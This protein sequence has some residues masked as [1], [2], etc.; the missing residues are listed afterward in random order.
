MGYV[1][2]NGVLKKFLYEDG[3]EEVVIPNNVTTIGYGAF[4]NNRNITSVI[5]PESIEEI[6][7]LAFKN[8]TKLKEIK[9]SDNVLKIGDCAFENCRNISSIMI[10]RNII[11]IKTDA[12]NDCIRLKEIIFNGYPK[13]MHGEVFSNTR[14]ERN[15]PDDFIVIGDLLYKYKGNDK[16]IEIPKGIKRIGISAFA[17]TD[18]ESVSIPNY[19]E[20]ISGSAFCGCKKLVTVSLPDNITKIETTTFCN[21]ESLEN[22]NIEH[23]LKIGDFA[24]QGCN[25]FSNIEL[26][27]G[28]KSFEA[29]SFSDEFWNEK[30]E[31]DFVIND[32]VLIRY[33]GKEKVVEVPDNVIEIGNGAFK[34]NHVVTE[35]K[36]LDRV[37]YIGHGAFYEC[38][39]LENISLSKSLTKI[40]NVVFQGCESLK[41]ISIPSGVIEIGNG[42]FAFCD[43]LISIKLPTTLTKFGEKIFFGHNPELVIRVDEECAALKYAKSNRIKSVVC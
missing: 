23:I 5:M 26:F 7:P 25:R 28:E 9:M 12:F 6:E 17:F 10:P 16:K 31:N 37:S 22:I 24:F 18:I 42:A 43:N 40:G 32:G 21:C 27:E 14:W 13:Y 15:Y 29:S 19:V 36:M 8:C 30:I 4:Y 1:I 39:S 2:E 34:G 38:S 35:I 20:Y 33:C 11:E 41:E 3:L